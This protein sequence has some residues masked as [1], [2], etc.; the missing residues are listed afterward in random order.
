MSLPRAA[1]QPLPKPL[2][3]LL[4][5]DER[6]CVEIVMA[7]LAPIQWAPLA[8]E[9]VSTLREA[10]ARLTLE[11]FD[12]V[13]CDLNLPDSAG[14]ATLQAVA[15]ACDRLIIVITANEEPGLRAEAL[16]RG[17]YD[18]LHKGKLTAPALDSRVAAS[19]LFCIMP[20]ELAAP[21]PVS[22][23]MSPVSSRMMITSSSISV[24]EKRSLSL[25]RR[26]IGSR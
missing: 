1:E 15:R 12:L 6:L 4:I 23:S 16:E 8:I 18:L 21:V 14:L 11:Q 2:R 19:V 5:E 25:V 17:A 9:A 3:I 24:S 26:F 7:C 20:P 13:I 22:E 10:L